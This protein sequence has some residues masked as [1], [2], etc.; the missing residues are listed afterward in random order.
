MRKLSIIAFLLTLVASLLWQ[1]QIASADEL[2]GMP[3]KQ[4]FVI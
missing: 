2:T 3:M 4:V 1:P